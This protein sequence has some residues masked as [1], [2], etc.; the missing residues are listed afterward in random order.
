M[1]GTYVRQ[2]I[3]QFAKTKLAWNATDKE[4]AVL[5]VRL[6]LDYEHSAQAW[7]REEELVESGMRIAYSVPRHRQYM[8]SGYPS[9]P[10]L[11]EAAA[12]VW[13]DIQRAGGHIPAIL[14]RYI[15][16]GL[17]RK[18]E[19]GELVARLLLLLAFD[20]A[21]QR[22][23][24]ELYT[25]EVKLIDF[26]RELFGDHHYDNTI[27]KSKPSAGQIPFDEAF[28]N[29]HVRFTHFG[30]NRNATLANTKGASAAILRSMAIQCHSGQEM[31]D[32]IIPVALKTQGLQEENMSAVTISIKDRLVPSTKAKVD[33]RASKISFFPKNQVKYG[34]TEHGR[35]YMALILELGTE[36]TRNPPF[37]REEIDNTEMMEVDEVDDPDEIEL[38]DKDL[39]LGTVIAKQQPTRQ[40]TRSTANQPIVNPC[41]TVYAYGCTSYVYKVVK[42]E[43]LFSSLLGS[44]TLFDEHPSAVPEE[45]IQRLKPLWEDSKACLDWYG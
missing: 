23:G 2:Q 38:S 11:A 29:A 3:V 7:L 30:R 25:T 26:L 1:A 32:I 39:Q 5:D 34:G 44:R 42:N 22:A 27:A 10:I 19:R 14:E 12:S 28:K 4:L 43:N 16:I 36:P 8:Y 31:I 41:Y 40:S 21:V 37:N 18:G 6:L 9:E 24:G 33:I 17:I 35:P 15:R 45:R 20:A 13:A